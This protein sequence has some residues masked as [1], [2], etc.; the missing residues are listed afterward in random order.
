MISG[1]QAALRRPANSRSLAVR[2]D[3]RL[4]GEQSRWLSAARERVHDDPGAIRTLFP[5]VGR[6]VGREHL[7]PWADPR[8]PR[9][10]TFDDTA[11]VLLLIAMGP[12]ARDHI[13]ELYRHGDRAERRGVVR[14]L[15]YLEDCPAATAIVER[16]LRCDDA[17]LVAAVLHPHTLARM[18]QDTLAQA[19]LKCVFIGVPLHGV[20]IPVTPALSAMLAR[21]AHERVAAGRDVPADVWPLIQRHPPTGELAAL[22]DELDHPDPARRGAARRALESR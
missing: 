2:L 1:E 6:Q 4:T 14:A 16:T 15:P 8:D 3:V 12:P 10:W 7:N 11:R 20:D 5:A 13:A 19:V 9:A 21:Y 22:A 17:Q 18:H